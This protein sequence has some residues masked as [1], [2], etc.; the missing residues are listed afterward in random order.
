MLKVSMVAL[1]MGFG[2]ATGAQA[3][4]LTGAAAGAV[5]CAGAAAVG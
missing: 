3:G 5:G 4:C 1:L 2:L